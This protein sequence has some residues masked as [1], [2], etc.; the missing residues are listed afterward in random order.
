MKFSNFNVLDVSVFDENGELITELNTLKDSQLVIQ[1]GVGYLHIVDALLDQDL[2]EYI[3]SA[4]EEK[5]S[6]FEKHL[7]RQK[8]SKTITFNKNSNKKCK[9]IGRGFMRNAED[10][11]DKEYLFEIPNAEIGSGVDFTGFSEEVSVYD[12]VFKINPFNEEGDL[13]KMHI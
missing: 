1:A 10:F 12:F 2:L 3:G 6:D 13:F 5:M 8:F 9:I 11:K 7:L 4:E